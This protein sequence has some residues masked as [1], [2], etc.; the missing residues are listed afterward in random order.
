M[1]SILDVNNV[2]PLTSVNITE[3]RKNS[4]TYNLNKQQIGILRKIK[5]LTILNKN[6][7]QDCKYD[8]TTS[9]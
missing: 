7:S 5:R 3:C 9:V 8:Y 6:N 4:N 2:F 1:E